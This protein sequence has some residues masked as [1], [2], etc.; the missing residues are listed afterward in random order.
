MRN[1]TVAGESLYNK[2]IV[3]LAGEKSWAASHSRVR[4]ADP[5]GVDVYQNMS[6]PLAVAALA[7]PSNQ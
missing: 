6:L 7:R 5:E 4:K 1:T 3:S 2:M